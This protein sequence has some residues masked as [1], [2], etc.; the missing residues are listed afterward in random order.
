MILGVK[1]VKEDGSPLD[2]S[3]ALVRVF[4][5]FVSALV[6]FLGF[7]WAG[8]SRQK[9]SWHDRIAGKVVIRGN[10]AGIRPPT[11]SQRTR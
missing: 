3:T 11:E 7:F 10:S 8:W 9:Q 1:V 5:S 4:A 2:V 6:L